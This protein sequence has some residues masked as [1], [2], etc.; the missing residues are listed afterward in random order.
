MD[1][2]LF[3]R[4]RRAKDVVVNDSLIPLRTAILTISRRVRIPEFGRGICTRVPRF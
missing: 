3:R 2:A 1:G 4:I